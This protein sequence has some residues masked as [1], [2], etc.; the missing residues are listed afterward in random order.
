MLIWLG[1]MKLM[2]MAINAPSQADDPNEP[3]A[4][5]AAR[6]PERAKLVRL[7]IAQPDG[8]HIHDQIHDQIDDRRHLAEDLIGRLNRRQHRERD[9]E[10][11]NDEAP[12]SSRI[13]TGMPCAL[14]FCRQ[15]GR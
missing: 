13:G 8:R 7:G 4:K 2:A 12:C 15:C 11:R 3:H 6:Y 10:N 14:V 9:A 5:I 1:G